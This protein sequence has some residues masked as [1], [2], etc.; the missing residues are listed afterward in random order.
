MKAFKIL[1]RILRSP[2]LKPFRKLLQF[3]F[4]SIVNFLQ[5]PLQKLISNSSELSRI[6]GTK[7]EQ[8]QSIKVSV[9][10]PTYNGI[11][12]GLERLLKSIQ[13]QTH[14]NTEIIAIDSSSTDKTQHLLAQYGANIITIPKDQFRHDYAR[15]LG[16]KSA[17]GQYLLFTVQDAC[18]DNKDWLRIALSHFSHI[19]DLVSVTSYQYA[20][21]DEADLYAECLSYNFLASVGYT[22]PITLLGGKFFSKYL[23]RYFLREPHLRARRIHVDDT[24][25]LVDRLFFLS[26][27]YDQNTCEDMGFGKKIIFANKKFAFTRL[28]SIT[29]HHAYQRP[30]NYAK[31]VFLDSLVI[32]QL[33]ERKLPS[34]TEAPGFCDAIF[35]FILFSA[36]YIFDFIAQEN[37]SSYCLSMDLKKAHKNDLFFNYSKKLRNS[38]CAQLDSIFNFKNAASGQVRAKNLKNLKVIELANA[39]GIPELLDEFNP[40]LVATYHENLRTLTQDL[41]GIITSFSKILCANKTM[42]HLEPFQIE[43][44]YIHCLVNIAMAHLSQHFEAYIDNDSKTLSIIK[45]WTWI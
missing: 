12:D 18:F 22:A 32:N 13:Q 6:I 17:T 14:V 11:E 1:M 39:F 15:N 21:S 5:S 35:I 30:E 8:L 37:F 43:M 40:A 45:K 7:P 3:F 23:W 9:I 20:P 16:A 27:L 24:N 34:P 10:I 29:H 25:H 44:F 31:R 42:A 2:L 38:V 41:S 36:G 19:Q 28:I 26:H 4:P 33:L